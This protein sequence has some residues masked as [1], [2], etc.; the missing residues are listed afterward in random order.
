[1]EKQVKTYSLNAGLAHD[2]ES[3]NARCQFCGRWATYWSQAE[4]PGGK[5]GGAV[6]YHCQ[7]HRK[8]ARALAGQVKKVVKA[9][10]KVEIDL[11]LVEVQD[12]RRVADGS[13][14]VGCPTHYYVLKNLSGETVARYDFESERVLQVTWCDPGISVPK[15]VNVP[16]YACIPERDMTEY[17]DWLREVLSLR[18]GATSL[19]VGGD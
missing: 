11:F 7:A 10:I 5:R 14:E 9:E 2:N 15:Y 4:K 1:M 19:T 13:S 6:V 18:P 3:L 8:Q 12:G 17:K 16:P